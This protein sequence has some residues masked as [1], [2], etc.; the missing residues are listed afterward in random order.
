MPL[1]TIYKGVLR[2]WCGSEVEITGVFSS[3]KDI[4][5]KNG[6]ENM[7]ASHSR[8]LGVR[9]YLGGEYL[10]MVISRHKRLKIALS[11]VDETS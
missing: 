3:E 4:H 8:R 9:F 2:E 11:L 10:E 5:L 6:K 7:T 1:M